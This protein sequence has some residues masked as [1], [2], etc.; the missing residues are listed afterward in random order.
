M[1]PRELMA[2]TTV[3]SEHVVRGPSFLD[4]VLFEIWFV[5]VGATLWAALRISTEHLGRWIFRALRRRP[6]VAR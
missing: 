6:G 3:L 5:G 4:Q 1:S 2:H